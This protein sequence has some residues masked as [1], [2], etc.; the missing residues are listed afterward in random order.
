M[1]P[2]R[3]RIM[4]EARRLEQFGDAPNLLD[5]PATQVLP[6][7]G[8]DETKLNFDEPTDLPAHADLR[9]TGRKL[10][11]GWRGLKLAVRGDSSFF[12]HGY[13]GTLIAIAGAFLG[14]NQWGWCLLII[15]ACL[16]LIAELGSSA[17][18]TLARAIGD[19]EE[20]RLKTAREIAT[21]GV[22]VAA[23]GAG[24]ITAIVLW[25]KFFELM[26]WRL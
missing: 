5:E 17:V 23:L 21:A 20:S 11:A 6:V 16:V 22:L 8:F 13:R 18:D 10:A 14:I 19:P 4:D 9:N 12:A 25:W 3:E 26:G 15:A 2:G 7:P 24:A 1:K